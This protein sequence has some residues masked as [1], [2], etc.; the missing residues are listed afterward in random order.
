MNFTGLSRA[1]NTMSFTLRKYSPQI[2]VGAGIIGGAVTTVLACVATA[3]SREVVEEA[4]I[5]LDIIDEHLNNPELNKEDK[6]TEAEAK[7]DKRQ[8]YLHTAGK[9]VLN[10]APA[11]GTGIASTA[12]ILGGTGILNKRNAVLA[13]SLA[14]TIGEFDDYRRK[15]KEKFGEDGER[16]DNELRFGTE[17][18]EIKEKVVGDDGKTKTVKKKI[19]IVDSGEDFDGYRRIFDP[20]NPYW[21][22]DPTYCEVF[23][24][25]RQAMFNDRLR[26]Y[27]YVFL[28]DVLE[29]LGFPKTRVGQEV[30][31]VFDP[32][33]QS[34]DNYIDFGIKP[35]EIVR[36]DGTNEYTY[37]ENGSRNSGFLLDFNV[38]GSVLNKASFPDQK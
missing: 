38:D 20:R 12:S 21:D 30:G 31:W 8:V 9:L 24:S 14:A 15:L 36:K 7:K 4:K 33:N 2:M 19:N 32:D 18:L 25:A 35:V 17:T 22:K 6:Y 28:N 27:G 29:E 1:V 26:A 5:N 3:K 34:G 11:I 16:I 13:S 10:Y 37:I 23:L